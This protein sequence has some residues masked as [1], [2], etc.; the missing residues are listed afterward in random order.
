VALGVLL[1]QALLHSHYTAIDEYDDGVYFGASVEL[2]H[3]VFAY[4]S[5]A[6]IQPPMI[7]LWMLP[8]AATSMAVG[9]ATAMEVARFFVDLVAVANIVLLGA[10]VR[11]RST[12]QVV[13]AVGV[14]AFSAGT[15]RSTQTIL[16]E[17]FLVLAC[18]LAFLCLMDGEHVTTSSRRL[19][20]CGIFLGVAGATKVW[21]VFAL[22]AVM[23]VV[24]R[25]QTAPRT[26]VWGA[27]TG[28]VTCCLPF[29]AAAPTGFFS[30]IVLTQALR[31][32]GGYPFLQ[33][34][35]DLTGLPGL[36]GAVSRHPLLGLT[37]LSLTVVFGLGT[38]AVVRRTG[39]GLP[40]TPLERLSAWTAAIVAVGLLL[41]PTY[42]Y[43]YSGFMAPFL[44]LV[45]SAL[46]ARL[47]APVRGVLRR[48]RL[49]P[50]LLATIAVPS[51]VALLAGASVNEVFTSPVAPQIGDSVSDAIPSRGCVLYANPSL[52]LLDDR[53]TS[54]VSGC[55]RVI[56]WLGQERV[57]DEGQSVTA[58][59]ARNGPLQ[60]VLGRW[61][62]SAD[63]VVLNKSNL[64]LD[65]DNVDYLTRRFDRAD[66]IP[67][68]IRIYVRPSPHHDDDR[69][70]DRL[71]PGDTS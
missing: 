42:Y 31:N 19:W 55:P 60:G 65:D 26:I 70:D 51:A 69:D 21:A 33:R 49:R 5:F 47:G 29:I 62:E 12:L 44:A 66:D 22:I 14:M 45:V 6:F 39:E 4:R 30:Q 24:R 58:S 52:A 59:D 3:G 9:T 28:F 34:L 43:H 71:T 11:R 13:A 20:W 10:L 27:L 25:T 54:D 15:I 68:G 2:F 53:F 8:F 67:R 41:S 35:A 50:T 38:V 16:L 63:A 23:L 40:W 57:L 64:G 32:G 1:L 61:I 36:A 48:T 7:I 46:V 17:P 37:L 18:L 56:D